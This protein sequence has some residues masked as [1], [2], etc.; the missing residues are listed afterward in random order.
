MPFGDGALQHPCWQLRQP[1]CAPDEL[2]HQQEEQTLRA[3]HQVRLPGVLRPPSPMRWCTY[4]APTSKVVNVP[5][6]PR[7]GILVGVQYSFLSLFFTV[8]S[9]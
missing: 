8:R 1:L 2:Q 5:R 6:D 3:R 9:K 4:D 7:L